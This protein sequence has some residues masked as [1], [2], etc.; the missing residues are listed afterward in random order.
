GFVLAPIPFPGAVHS[1]VYWADTSHNRIR[2]L[3]PIALSTIDNDLNTG[4]GTPSFSGVWNPLRTGATFFAPLEG[5]SFTTTLYFI[6][7]TTNIAGASGSTT[8]TT[9]AFGT[10]LFPQLVPTASG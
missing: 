2:I 10:D 7:P 9:R 4:F 1:R 8:S 5:T 3:E 6:C